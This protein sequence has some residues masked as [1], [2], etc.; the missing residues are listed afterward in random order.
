[1]TDE[2]RVK[3]LDFGLAKLDDPGEFDDVAPDDVPTATTRIAGGA[4]TAEGVVVGTPAYMSPEQAAGKRVD[5][6]SDMFSF[7]IVLYELLSGVNPFGRG[8]HAATLSA[9][10]HDH[11]TP[12]HKRPTRIAPELDTL[13]LRCL[14]K[15]SRAPAAKHGGLGGPYFSWLPDG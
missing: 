2:G 1:M 7:G 5:A 12:L 11:P 6:R 13:I 3:V 15:R 8:S 4:Y 9:I 10:L 14:R